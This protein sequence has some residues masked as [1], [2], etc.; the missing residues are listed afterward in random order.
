MNTL[1]VMTDNLTDIMQRLIGCRAL[2]NALYEMAGSS[3][4]PAAA[5][6]GIYDLLD[7]ICRDFQADIDC[8]EEYTMKEGGAA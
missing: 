5:I 1:P 7:C 6:S 3:A 8:V 4:V 2:V